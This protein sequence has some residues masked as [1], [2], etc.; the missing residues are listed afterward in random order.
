MLHQET[1]IGRYLPV[2]VSGP[3]ICAGGIRVCNSAATD[4]SM[5][6]AEMQRLDEI[7][8]LCATAG[9]RYPEEAM[10]RLNI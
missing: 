7:F 2:N 3:A 6:A 9:P 4:L 8:L 5:D 10:I 1:R